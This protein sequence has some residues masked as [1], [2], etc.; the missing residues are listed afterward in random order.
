M[1]TVSWQAL[2]LSDKDAKSHP[3]KHV[4]TSNYKYDWNKWKNWNETN[5][6]LSK[7]SLN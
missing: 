5:E 7:E 4:S 2:E 3:N 1:S 6:S